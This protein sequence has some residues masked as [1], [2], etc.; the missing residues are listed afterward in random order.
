MV[1][2]SLLI[3]AIV[4]ALAFP[5]TGPAAVKSNGSV[6]TLKVKCKKQS[7]TPSQPKPPDSVYQGVYGAGSCSGN[8]KLTATVAGGKKLKAGKGK[9]SIA[10][11]KT[12]TVK[13]KLTR[14]AAQA[15]LKQGRLKVKVALK[16]SAPAVAA[17]QLTITPLKPVKKTAK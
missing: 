12:I 14:K 6:V 2:A 8:V 10:P 9:F 7:S 1:R 15:L 13:A 5:A 3:A 17:K 16:S 11:G 4:A